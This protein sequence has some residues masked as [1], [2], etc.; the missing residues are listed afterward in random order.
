M[1]LGFDLHKR[2]SADGTSIVVNVY[3]ALALCMV[4]SSQ[5]PDTLLL[6]L[7]LPPLLL[8]FCDNVLW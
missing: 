1:H 2:C 7:L 4:W 6:L 3:L 8:Q 5:L